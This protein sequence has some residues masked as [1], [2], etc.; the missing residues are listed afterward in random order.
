VDAARELAQL[1][2]GLGRLH[3]GAGHERG[4]GGG[5]LLELGLDDAEQHVERHEALLGAVVQVA[6]DA[7]ALVVGGGED[8]RAGVLEALDALAQLDRARAEH[9]ARTDAVE[10]R[11]AVEEVQAAE[12]QQHADGH[13]GDR[14][15][16][17][18]DLPA[19]EDHGRDRD[20]HRREGEHDRADA[21]QEDAR[22][23]DDAH[24]QLAEQED[25]R[26]PGDGVAQPQLHALAPVGVDVALERRVDRDPQ[27]P[28]G[29][30][31]L[32]R[33]QRAHGE[34]RRD[35]Q[36]EADDDHREAGAD[37]QPGDQDRDVGDAE[38]QG[39]QQVEQVPVA[40]RVPRDAGEAPEG[41][42][43]DAAP[44]VAPAHEDPGCA[45]R[46]EP[47]LHQRT[48]LYG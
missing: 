41:R 35:E 17:V 20:Q 47:R 18:V 27:Q 5:V 21:E 36:H 11:E 31:A 28:A 37:R 25:E 14:G 24:R 29:E 9:D 8:A 19:E 6:L 34:Q 3:A 12:E 15:D 16:R 39:E 40:L 26:L 2:D 4:S 32:D 13:G 1:L 33:G 7:A 38:R 22:V 30:R 10:P 48:R 46:S 23:G 42:C 45:H 43:G 44:A